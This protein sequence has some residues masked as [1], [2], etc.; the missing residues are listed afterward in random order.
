MPT[1]RDSYAAKPE[2]PKSVDN[3]VQQIQQ[4]PGFEHVW[5]IIFYGSGEKRQMTHE[6]DIDL[7]IYYDGDYTEAGKFRHAVLS[8]LP[9][10]CYDVKIFQ[11][12]PLYVRIEALKGTPV[13]IRDLTFL[14]ETANLTLRE[15][16]DFKH[17]LYDYTGQ[18]AIT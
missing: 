18:A 5:F 10:I 7:C 14:Y 17:R 2:I 1:D 11:Q 3:A 12:L 6:S 13:F 15:F 16:D 9:G 8:R 4:V